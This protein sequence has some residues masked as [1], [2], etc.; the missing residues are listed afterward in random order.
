[1][2]SGAKGLTKRVEDIKVSE[3]SKYGNIILYRYNFYECT[4]T[5]YLSL[6]ETEAGKD[7]LNGKLYPFLYADATVINKLD[8]YKTAMAN[9][10]NPSSFNISTTSKP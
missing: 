6:N 4:T 7:A 10:E 1:M 5:T 2:T 9:S 3:W 8:S